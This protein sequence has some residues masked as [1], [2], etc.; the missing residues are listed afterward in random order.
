[1]DLVYQICHVVR[2]ANEHFISEVTGIS[3]GGC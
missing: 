1:M 2:S 3:N